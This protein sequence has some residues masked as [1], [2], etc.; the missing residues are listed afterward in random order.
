MALQAGWYRVVHVKSQATHRLRALLR[1]RAMLVG[2]RVDLDNHLR[3]ILKAFGLKVGKVRAE[4]FEARVRELVENDAVLQQIVGAILGVRA[5]LMQRLEGL[6]RLVLMVVRAD[7]VCRRLMTVPGV[8]PVTAL[9]FRTA[10]EDPARFAKASLL[11]SYFG[12]TPRK[13]ASG[14]VD[15]NGGISKCGDK[16]VRSLLCEAA[17]ASLIRVKRWSALKH[18]AVQVARRRGFMRAKVALARRLAVIMHRIW[19]DGTTFQWTRETPAQAL[20]TLS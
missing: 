12:L 13:Y 11:G 7:P 15:R 1:S 14:D 20:I 2:T 10:V 18:W 4:H 9:A 16:L 19:I 17:N 3:G 5:E 8:G 6:D